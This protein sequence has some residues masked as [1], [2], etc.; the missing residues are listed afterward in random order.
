MNAS[1][2]STPLPG[3]NPIGNHEDDVLERAGVANDFARQVLELDAGHG[4]TVGVFGPWGSGKTSF[5]NLARKTFERESVPVLDFNPWLFS[6]AEQLVERFFAEL[7]ASMGM[8]DELEE[9]GDAFRRYG[10]ALNAV[11]GV[12]SALLAVPQI[13]AIVAKITEAAGNASQPE[14]V[15][16]LRKKIEGAL[17]ERGKSIIVVLDDVDRLSAPEIREVF[18]LVRLTAGFPNLIYIVSCDRLRVEQALGEQA[19]GL[20]GRDYL[21]KIIQWSFNLPEVPSHLLARQLEQAIK[22]ALAAIE[23]PGRL[24]EEVWS[25]ARVEI[26]RPLIRNM[27]DVRRYAIAVRSTVG[28]LEGQV[29]LA[30]VLA[31]EAVRVFLPDV[32]GLLSGAIDGLTG[33][34]QAVERRVD[35]M[36][37][38]VLEDPFPGL[39]KWL[40][41]QVDG[42]ST[43]AGKDRAAE[44]ARTAREVVEATVDNLFPV[45]AGLRS[46][47][48]GNSDPCVNHDAAKHLRERR[49]AHEHIFRRYLE[50]TTSPE[51]LAFHDAERALARMAD[52]NRLTEFIHS[53]GSPRWQG[54]VSNLR[55]LADRFRPEHVEPGVV[56]LLDL[57]PDMQE[58]PSR[59]SVRGS[60]AGGTVLRV[61]LQLLGVLEDAADVE[62]A[63]RRILP[64]VT[65]LGSKAKFVHLL[66]LPSE[67]D[68]KFVS[69]AAANE[70]KT[71]LRNEIRVA[72]ADSLADERD[73]YAALVFAKRC[74]E[75]TDEPF[76]IDC[77]PK[78]TFALLQSVRGEMRTESIG[79]RA[80]RRTAVLD[81]ECLIDL[82]GGEDVLETRFN[83]LKARIEILKPWLETR[84]IPLDEAEQLLELADRYLSGWR[85]DAD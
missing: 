13:G 46:L 19:P 53:L 68:H 85:P 14:S 50:R 82:Y 42:L 60:D 49:V 64:E 40:K 44:A 61:T 63:V 17:R 2:N 35:R 8:T 62:A 45:G 20:S 34:T 4:T 83:D 39:N 9:I 7:S 43:A 23:N 25:K 76:E 55:D 18:K 54:V 84:P 58:R 28:G 66:T 71:M 81:W 70:F 51:L 47:S 37:L 72:P 36:R 22:R 6:G 5:V 10:A 24:D 80:V 30:D 12:A 16:A 38:Q 57:L 29:A 48:D 56:V 77:S 26:V 41:K 59:S 31:L 27:R 33:M 21:E 73:P 75:P 78:L 52:R 74:G 1:G 32:F 65:S 67:S 79:S 3:D 69:K 15:D 11:A